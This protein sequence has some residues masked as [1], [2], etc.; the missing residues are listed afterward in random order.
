[1]IVGSPATRTILLVED[2][3][4]DVL[5]TRPAFRQ[6]GFSIQLIVARDGQEALDYLFGEGMYLH[7]DAYQ[8]PAVV[9]LDLELPRVAGLDVLRRI[10]ADR[11]THLQPVVMLSS[12]AEQ[13][14]VTSCYANGANG[15]VRKTV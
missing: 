9:L 13:S 12:S 2:N 11:R 1:M 5:L 10:R 6:N 15:Y 3:D 7:S 8:P 4:A 14:D